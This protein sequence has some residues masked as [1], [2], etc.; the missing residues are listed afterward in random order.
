MRGQRANQILWSL[1]SILLLTKD[2]VDTFVEAKP[3]LSKRHSQQDVISNEI[4]DDHG[5]SGQQ[6]WDWNLNIKADPETVTDQTADEDY[7]NYQYNEIDGPDYDEQ[8]QLRY[9]VY[10]NKDT[11][12]STTTTTTTTPSTTNAK[13]VDDETIED[14]ANRDDDLHRD[15]F[16]IHL[17]SPYTIGYPDSNPTGDAGYEA[18]PSSSYGVS[19]HGSNGGHHHSHHGGHSYKGGSGDNVF[20]KALNWF[21]PFHYTGGYRQLTF[22]NTLTNILTNSTFIW[23]PPYLAAVSLVTY[24]L[25]SGISLEIVTTVNQTVGGRRRRYPRVMG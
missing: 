5:D 24:A 19:S 14:E 23:W 6:L 4:A 21:N 20:Y 3:P 11:T 2:T 16:L 18:D 15:P 7:Y 9:S 13:E 25:I 8:G 17:K 10:N 12:T 22:P 1:I